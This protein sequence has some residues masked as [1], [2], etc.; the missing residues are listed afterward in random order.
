MEVAVIGAGASG[1]ASAARLRRRGIP[2]VVF[3]RDD[4][5]GATWERRYDRLRLNSIRWLS[6]QPG[7]RMPRSYGR[8]VGRDDIAAYLRDYAKHHDIDVRLSSTVERVDRDPLG[9]RVNV[10]GEEHP[11][12][13]VVVATGFY[14]RGYIPEWPGRESFSGELLH[15]E[16][17]RNA[18]PFVG[19]DV[20]VVGPG[21]S[22]AEI[23]VDLLEGGA[24]RVRIAIR[25]PP[26]IFPRE[27]FGLPLHPFAVLNRRMP[28]KAQDVNGRLVQWLAFGNLA[29][30][31]I[32]RCPHGMYTY[33]RNTGVGPTVDSG[34]VAGVKSGRIEVVPALAGFDGPDVLLANG[35][36]IQPDAVVACTGYR[37]SLDPLLGHLGMLPTDRTPLLHGGDTYPSA[38]RMYFAGFSSPLS[39]HLYEAM[40]DVRQIE[41]LIVRDRRLGWPEAAASLS[42]SS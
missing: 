8:W 27:L 25:T 32:G 28:I 13:A 5:I 39:G 16:R 7:L 24:G 34:F 10:D 17:Y 1:L 33:L 29:K 15:A 9:W 31:P 12:R 21:N 2:A 23:A 20:L 22:G 41:R 36:R 26:N 18:E 35:A 30:T 14:G 42:P 3:E 40:R 11:V 4:H 38:P 6:D 37:H 19:R